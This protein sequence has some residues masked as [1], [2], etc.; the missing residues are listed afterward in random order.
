MD[1]IV[2]ILEFI[3]AHPDCNSESLDYHVVLDLYNSGYVDGR[4]ASTMACLSFNHLRLTI[5]GDEYLKSL[6][7]PKSEHNH[8]ANPATDIVNNW[9]NKPIGKI[10]VG[11]SIIV[12][13]AVVFWV[14][15]H[16]FGVRL[17]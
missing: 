1:S 14:A 7:N 5:S 8:A 9:H 11:V 6:K 4:N 12:L 15:Y 16:Y 17:G 10:F 2:E 13:S 3:K